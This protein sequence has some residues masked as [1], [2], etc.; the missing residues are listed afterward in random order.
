[1]TGVT[2]EMFEGI[3]RNKIPW[4]PKIDQKKCV[5]CGKC[6]DFCH[7][8]AFGFEEKEGEKKTVVKNINAC[9]VFCRGCEDICPAGAISHPSEEKTRKIIIRL[10]EKPR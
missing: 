9:V 1:V 7:A 3:P 6:V 2:E 4:T 5:S 8:Q 10:K